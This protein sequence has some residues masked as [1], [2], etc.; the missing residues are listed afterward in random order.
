MLIARAGVN[1]V[2]LDDN[3]GYK[4]FSDTTNAKKFRDAFLLP[5][6]GLRYYG[7][8]APIYAQGYR[9]YYWSSS[10]NDS[11]ARDLDVG[12]SDV[13]AHG[14]DRAYGFSLRCFKD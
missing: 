8:S 5:L 12:M 11:Y 1:G 4:Y 9:S 13:Y 10:P 6:A 14:G 2:S 7:S 3:G